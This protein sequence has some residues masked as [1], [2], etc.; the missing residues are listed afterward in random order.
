MLNSL[1]IKRFRALEDFSVSRLGR[2]NL[3][4][5]KNNAGKSTVLEALQ[6]YAAGGSVSLLETL[7]RQHGEWV[8]HERAHD[9]PSWEA[10]QLANRQ[11][12]GSAPFVGFF[13][14]R[15]FPDS[16]EGIEIGENAAESRLYI[17]HGYYLE[18]QAPIHGEADMQALLYRRVSKDKTAEAETASQ[19]I[20]LQAALFI[21]KGERQSIVDLNG[22][23]IRSGSIQTLPCACIP[24]GFVSMDDMANEWDNIALTD[25]QEVVKSALQLMTPDFMDISFVKSNDQGLT[26]T[27]KIRLRGTPHPVP[28][29]SMGDGMLR[30]LQITLK[31]FAA[32]GG[33]LLID[34][35]ENGLHYS[36]QEKIWNLIFQLAEQLDIQ[37]FATTHSWDCIESFAKVAVAQQ[38]SEG[39]LFRMGRSARTSDHGKVIATV[40]DE[41]Q[42]QHITQADVEVR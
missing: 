36:V 23:H 5:G 9:W 33:L 13:S 19:A 34:E 30:V 20:A 21:K 12:D 4:V 6:I 1:K 27:A 2:V 25:D 3:M 42:L 31:I 40:F 32:R 11:Q 35:F 26:R 28:L 10:Q 18:W 41:A 22:R 16:D 8:S 37:V 38:G 7:A 39:V 14:G 17:E 24:S 15:I 29:G